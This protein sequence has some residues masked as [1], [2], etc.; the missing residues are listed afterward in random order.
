MEIA[1]LQ[2][3]GIN[4]TPDFEISGVDFTPIY[5]KTSEGSERPYIA[6]FTYAVIRAVHLELV[7]NISAHIFILALQRFFFRRGFCKTIYSGNAN[8]SSI[9]D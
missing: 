9:T 4:E 7:P 3:D 5:Y 2:K 1:P 6:I 8:T